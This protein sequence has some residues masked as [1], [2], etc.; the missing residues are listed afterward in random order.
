MDAN[1]YRIRPYAASLR[2][3]RNRLRN[4]WENAA[5]NESRDRT[6]LRRWQEEVLDDRE[7]SRQRWYERMDP[8]FGSYGAIVGAGYAGALAQYIGKQGTGRASI[9]RKYDPDVSKWTVNHQDA[10][11]EIEGGGPDPD[12]RDMSA[13]RWARKGPRE[14][15]RQ[16]GAGGG[17]SAGK[18]RSLVSYS[19]K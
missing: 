5:G 4:S 14:F 18:I 8:G 19:W 9:K 1:A 12:V 16:D 6:R 7:A 3:G 2:S 10:P 11:V 17:G 15:T 13:Q